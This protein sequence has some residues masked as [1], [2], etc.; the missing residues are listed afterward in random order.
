MY[1]G[2]DT[3]LKSKKPSAVNFDGEVKIVTEATFNIVEKAIKYVVPANSDFMKK[4]EE[5][6]NIEIANYI[7]EREDEAKLKVDKSAKEMLVATM[8]RYSSDVSNSKA[9]S[10]ASS[11]K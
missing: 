3:M 9:Y 11:L 4:V 2:D 7:K 6:M 10:I 1:F 5:D 8:Q